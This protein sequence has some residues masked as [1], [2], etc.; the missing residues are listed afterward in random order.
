MSIEI[1][2]SLSQILQPTSSPRG[3][4][5][6]KTETSSRRHC[7]GSAPKSHTIPL[8]LCRI[9]GAGPL[10]TFSNRSPT[11]ERAMMTSAAVRAAPTS[12]CA[13]EAPA[14]ARLAPMAAMASHTL[15]VT[16]SLCF[17]GPSSGRDLANGA[18]DIAHHLRHQLGVVPFGHDADQRLGARRPDHDAAGRIQP[19]L[20][21]GDRSL[22][23]GVLER[24]GA[25]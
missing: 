10:V 6:G 9:L 16:P 12:G 25:A 14:A 2:T 24:L 11:A 20:A 21:V 22:D 4:P 7:T 1:R 3:R 23:L 19:G 18:G 8:A 5:D 15:I 13:R 17:L